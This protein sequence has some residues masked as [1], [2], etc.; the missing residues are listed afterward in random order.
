M[1]RLSSGMFGGKWC[2][3][4]LC[5]SGRGEGEFAGCGRSSSQLRD[6]QKERE[7]LVGPERHERANTCTGEAEPTHSPLPK[8]AVRVHGACRC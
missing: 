3:P 6:S 7:T 2:S 8:R 5:S 1:T 4:T